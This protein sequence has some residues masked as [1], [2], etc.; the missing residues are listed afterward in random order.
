[1]RISVITGGSRGDVQP[2]AVLAQELAARGHEVK[3]WAQSSF[4]NMAGAMGLSFYPLGGAPPEKV[5]TELEKYKP[6]G[7]WGKIQAILAPSRMEPERRM[8]I[9]NA[10]REVDG[11]VLATMSSFGKHAVEAAGLPYVITHV[12]PLYRTRFLPHPNLPFRPGQTQ[13]RNYLTHCAFDQIFWRKDRGWVNDWRTRQLALAPLPRLAINAPEKEHPVLFGY[14]PAILPPPP[15][16]PANCEVHGYW[17]PQSS[18]DPNP[19]ADLCAFLE[20]PAIAIGFGSTIPP[21]ETFLEEVCA[22]VRS[23][24]LRAVIVQGWNSNVKSDKDIFNVSTIDY[25]WLF[26]K[27][28]AVVHTG[29]S[30]VSS[31]AILSGV[32]SVT[33]PFGAD[34]RFWAWRLHEI[35]IASQPLYYSAWNPDSFTKR[36][37]EISQNSSFAL[38]A[39]KIG[40]VVRKERGVETA[41][42]RI[43]QHFSEYPKSQC[44]RPR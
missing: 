41:A 11:V 18:I 24:G 43:E 9:E 33:V 12:S 32:P 44:N 27:V 37:R 2:S 34:Q 5:M 6:R 14:S 20:K 36:L 22:S 29:G 31:M 42:D 4:R 19:P 7:Y 1:M 40:E 39:R 15:D 17:L 3:F 35:G 21:H 13:I 25:R 38:E 10:C 30:G 23:L 28:S 26:T 8:D 16:W